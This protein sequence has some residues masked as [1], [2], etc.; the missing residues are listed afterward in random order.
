MTENVVTRYDPHFHLGM[1]FM[2]LIWCSR[3]WPH[4]V[5]LFKSDLNSVCIF[6]M[7]EKA[8]SEVLKEHQIFF[9]NNTY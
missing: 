2:T 9:I 1:R 4:M 5:S 7:I 3:G 8:L 6:L